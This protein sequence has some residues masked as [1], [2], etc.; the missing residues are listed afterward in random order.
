[1]RGSHAERIQAQ[2]RWGVPRGCGRGWRE[3][4]KPIA[5]IT[6]LCKDKLGIRQS[7]GRVRSCFDNAAT[8]L[9]VSTLEH[10]VLSRTP[11]RQRA[12]PARSCWCGATSSTTPDGGTAP[13]PSCRQLAFEKITADQPA[14]ACGQSSPVGIHRAR[15]R[16]RALWVQTGQPKPR[17]DVETVARWR[18]AT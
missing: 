3:T 15:A 6:R 7:M 14:A 17:D 12:R 18:S 8:E 9:F 13:R 1:M 10:E 4:G 11:S 2:V 16:Y 5:Q